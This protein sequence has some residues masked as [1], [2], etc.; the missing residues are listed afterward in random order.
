[1]LYLFTSFKDKNLYSFKTLTNIGHIYFYKARKIKH[2]LFVY[3]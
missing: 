1:M 3:V 2:V